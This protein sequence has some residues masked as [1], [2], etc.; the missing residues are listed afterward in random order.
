MV[1]YGRRGGEM[2][3]HESWHSWGG[4]GAFFARGFACGGRGGGHRGGGGPFNFGGSPPGGFPF[5][6]GFPWTMFR[7][8]S[9]ARR[10]DVRTAILALLAEQPRNG[11]QIMQELG[12]R[13][14]GRWHPSAGSIYPT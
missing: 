14:G 7:R 10:G 1:I 9:R 3:T 13:S 2:D 6:P 11:Y 4:P 12:D 8:G 5:G